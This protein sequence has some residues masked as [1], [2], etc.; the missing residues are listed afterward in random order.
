MDKNRDQELM[1]EDRQIEVFKASTLCPGCGAQEKPQET[2]IKLSYILKV[3]KTKMLKTYLSKKIL[4]LF[5]KKS[6]TLFP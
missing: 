1:I 6:Q 3:M 5:I 2:F 4:F